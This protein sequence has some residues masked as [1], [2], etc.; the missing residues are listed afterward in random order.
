MFKFHVVQF[1]WREEYKYSGHNKSKKEKEAIYM[2]AELNTKKEAMLWIKN[3]DTK[4]AR[5]ATDMLLESVEF[6]KKTGRDLG[7]TLAHSDIGKIRYGG[8]VCGAM[9]QAK[10]IAGKE[11]T[12]LLEEVAYLDIKS[13]L[14]ESEIKRRGKCYIME[15]GSIYGADFDLHSGKIIATIKANS[16]E[17]AEKKW[18]IK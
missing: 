3:I 13:N 14:Y 9:L 17:E 16:F 7:S 1:P 12:P 15:H 6:S 5:K 2:Y 11:V 8:T 18:K 4:L 10:I